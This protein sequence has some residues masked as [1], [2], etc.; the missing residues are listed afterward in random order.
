MFDQKIGSEKA[1]VMIPEIYGIN[2]YI[3]DWADFF[4]H[5]GY[6]P[7]CV[8]LSGSERSF[9]YSDSEEAY[10]EF[11]ADN[12][13]ERYKKV[14]VYIREL[15]EQYEKIIVFGSSV[16]A[17]IAWRLTEN[18]SCDGMIGFYGSRIRDYLEVNPSCPCL[19]IF[20]EEE[21]SFDVRAIIPILQQKKNAH[22]EVLPGKHGFADL[23]G[24]DFHLQSGKKALD[25]VKYFLSEI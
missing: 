17:T 11:I 2:Q 14:A 15:R 18:K 8:E 20:P 21:K 12:G 10:D 16:G 22:V 5:Q 24:N 6:D 7:L 9:S 13:F 23:Y 4:K 25:M 3:K 19:L 1:V